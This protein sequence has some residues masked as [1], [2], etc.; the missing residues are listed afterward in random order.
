M[1]ECTNLVPPLVYYIY[2]LVTHAH[3]MTPKVADGPATRLGAPPAALSPRG[4]RAGA[5][6]VVGR[7]CGVCVALT[8]GS[9]YPTANVTSVTSNLLMEH[10]ERVSTSFKPT[11]TAANLR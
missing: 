1:Q 3:H 2:R 8:D 11:A 10:V 4:G 7:R 6:V 9:A 5:A